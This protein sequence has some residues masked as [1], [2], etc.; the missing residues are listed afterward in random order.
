MVGTCRIEKLEGL[1]SE[2]AMTQIQ[3]QYDARREALGKSV[4]ISRHVPS[5]ETCEM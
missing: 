1:S 2:Q 4:E 5:E 3:G